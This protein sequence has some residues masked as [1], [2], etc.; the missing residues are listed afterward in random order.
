MANS[1][2]LYFHSIERRVK[3]EREK[4]QLQLKPKETTTG[5]SAA[6]AAIVDFLRS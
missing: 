3:Q 2:S 4:K 1:I 5:G 6:A